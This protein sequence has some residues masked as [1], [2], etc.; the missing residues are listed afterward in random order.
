[1]KKLLLFLLFTTI[2]KAQIINFP[3][4]NFKAALLQQGLIDQNFNG[5]IEYNEA[6]AT[7]S[8]Y[9]NSFSINNVE[10]IQYFYNL[11]YLTIIGSN[12]QF[13]DLSNLQNL[14]SIYLNGNFY[15]GSINV[16]G[17]NN[18][19]T[20]TFSSCGIQ[21]FLHSNLN[22]LTYL[23]CNSCNLV[24]LDTSGMNNL[25][26]LNCGNNYLNSVDVSNL[27]NLQ[28]LDCS[29]E[30]NTNF[31]VL[32]LTGLNYLTHLNLS[33]NP[34]TVLDLSNL[35]NLTFL[36]YSNTLIPPIN[37]SSLT[38]LTYF[39]CEGN[40]LT[41]MDFSPL[42]NLTTLN[43]SHNQLASLNINALTLLD[44]LECNN[45]YLI[46]LNISNQSLLNYLDCTGN[47]L[48]TLD[49]SNNVTLSI[50]R[51]SYNLF[52]NLDFSHNPLMQVCN[53][54]YNPNL[55][56][57]NIKNGN[58]S[59]VFFNIAIDNCPNL[60]SICT[61][62]DHIDY[63]QQKIDQSGYTNT[64]HVNSYCNFTHGGTYYTI[65]GNIKLDSNNN[66]CDIND[67]VYPNLKFNITDGTISGNMISNTSG[68]YSIPVSAGAHTITPQFENPTYFN[69]SPTNTTVT[70]PANAS[71]AIRN[72]CITPNGVHHDI[73][74]VVIP[75]TFARPGFDATYKIKYKNK[76]NQTENATINFNYNDAILDYVSSNVV[77]TTQAT[78]TLSWNVGTNA[79]FQSGEI[80][81]TLN[82]NSPIETPAVNGGDILSYTATANG[83]NTDETTEDN[84]FTLPQVVVNSFDPNDK[85]C[86]EGATINPSNIGKYVHY[87][88]RFENTGTFAAQNIVVKDMIDTAKFDL[89][90]L[91]MTDASHSCVTRITNPNK[92][93]FIFE[94][95]NLPFDDN[96]NDGYVVFKIKTKPTLVVG[97]TISNSANIYFDYNFPIITNTAT[98]TFQTLQNETFVF[99]NYLTMYPNPVKEEINLKT[100]Q[101]TEIYSITIFNILGQ[102]VQTFIKPSIIIDVST[103]KTG[104]YIVKV[105]TDKGVSSS[106]FVKE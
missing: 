46:S 89:T 18:L 40:H 10:G 51:F 22:N 68:N 73:E 91:Q 104:N 100:K 25:T 60:I 77:P 79:P 44:R 48:T 13:L 42:V 38:Q 52:T 28:F 21:S 20:L 62:D 67:L 66:G 93:E 30:H 24:S 72:F 16:T 7:S 74:V 43:C 88:I 82:V 70:F 96:N 78:G 37:L 5:E 14:T 55:T 102:Q 3:D 92:V 75:T 26:Y 76:G 53:L 59:T 103:L 35:S 97:N 95:I 36:D 27:L 81:V 87:K 41:N 6:A 98:S 61:D 69:S 11:Q 23:N 99:D 45:N 50:A 71:P 33:N 31:N 64:C 9:L 47:Q 56:F 83:L 2:V 94:N 12:L 57:L 84:T 32:N 101:D 4:A 29:N 65:N 34:I 63:V 8:I 15:L 1:M 106:K 19:Q 86:L 58:N 17:L 80:L 39:G 90:S 105:V 49:L 54:Q 85:T